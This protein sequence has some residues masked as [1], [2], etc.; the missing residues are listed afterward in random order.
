VRRR[1]QCSGGVTA[2]G[3]GDRSLIGLDHQFAQSDG[4]FVLS[5]QQ[6][7]SSRVL[8]RGVAN[9]EAADSGSVSP[10]SF[11]GRALRV[12]KP[13]QPG[14]VFGETART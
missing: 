1:G 3:L 2:K 5:R 14:G 4:M 13:P 6:M 7:V 11:S 10:L 9:S 8:R 12:R